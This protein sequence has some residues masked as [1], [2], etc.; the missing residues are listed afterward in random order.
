M[1]TFQEPIDAL[2]IQNDS[3]TNVTRLHYLKSSLKGEAE[4]L[5]KH[6]IIK[7]ADFVLTWESSQARYD[8]KRALIMVY[9]QE[10][11]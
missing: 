4:Q 2:I 8:N 11:F 6:V 1:G 3:L 9:L 5:L 10:F 7:E